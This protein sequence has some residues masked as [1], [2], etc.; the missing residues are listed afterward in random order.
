MPRIVTAGSPRGSGVRTDG[1]VE[2]MAAAWRT[3]VGAGRPA[4]TTV[5]SI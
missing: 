4:P 1:S 3:W 2:L 5:P